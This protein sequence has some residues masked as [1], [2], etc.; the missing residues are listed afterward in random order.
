MTHQV[1]AH[2]VEVGGVTLWE[3][4]MGTLVQCLPRDTRASTSMAPKPNSL[5]TLRLA[6]LVT[7]FP[8]TNLAVLE[9]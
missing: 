4:C 3:S 6:P 1:L 5:L 2:S 7:Q 8:L 9:V